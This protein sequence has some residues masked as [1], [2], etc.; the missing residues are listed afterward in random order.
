MIKY[1]SGK[2]RCPNC[3]KEKKMS[4]YTNWLSKTIKNNLDKNVE[5][6]YWIFYNKSIIEKKTISKQMF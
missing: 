3:K 1:K 5:E 6:T 2:F 4:L